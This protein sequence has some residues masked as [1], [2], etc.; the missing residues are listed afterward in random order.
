MTKHLLLIVLSLGVMSTVNGCYPE[1]SPP[2]NRVEYRYER[3]REIATPG[4]YEQR[5]EQEE[6]QM[7]SG[8]ST[9]EREQMR[10]DFERWKRQMQTLERGR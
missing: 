2:Q 8:A 1:P 5:I 6:Q 10:Q 9:A 4:R 7:T 3:E